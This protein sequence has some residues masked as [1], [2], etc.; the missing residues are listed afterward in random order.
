MQHIYL[1]FYLYS[2]P[3]SH[4][5]LVTAVGRGVHLMIL[6]RGKHT[7]FTY[8]LGLYI[9]SS[10]RYNILPLQCKEAS[11]FAF[12]SNVRFHCLLCSLSCLTSDVLHEL[13]VPP[14]SRGRGVPLRPSDA[15]LSYCHTIYTYCL[16]ILQRSRCDAYSHSHSQITLQI[17]RRSLCTYLCSTCLTC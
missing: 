8:I 9:F 1:S 17:V 3:Y 2:Y 4:S 7:S 13:A 10:D 14:P 6:R 15:F 11:P 16:F 5:R 12:S